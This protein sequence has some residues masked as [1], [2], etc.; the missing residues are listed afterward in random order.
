MK[1]FCV[2]PA[3]N[4]A[5]NI[6]Q[7]IKEVL[8]AVDAV[9]VVDDCSTDKTAQAAAAAG[10]VVL[11]HLL[12]RGQGA[13]LRTG[14]ADA[15]DQGA[16]IIIHFD[17][18]GQFSAADLP[19]LTEPLR[20]GEAEIVFGS[21]FLKK[22]NVLPAAKRYLIMPTARLINRLFFG[23]KLTDPQSGLRALTAAAARCLSWRE[24]RMAHCSEILW[25]AHRLHLKI[26]EVP[27]TVSYRRFGQ[28]AGGGWKILKDLF[29]NKLSN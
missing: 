24:D 16:E 19:A 8:P 6:E 10:A 18:D 25:R 22:G 14:T 23:V 27:M 20:T 26:K 29:I 11:R 13:A 7:V 2:I 15:L 4:E 17:A 3:Y 1:T 21:R 5:K 9:V 28:S 12:N